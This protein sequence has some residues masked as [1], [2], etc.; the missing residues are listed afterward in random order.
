MEVEPKQDDIPEETKADSELTETDS[1]LGVAE[2]CM[3]QSQPYDR[4]EGNVNGIEETTV[5]HVKDEDS[6]ED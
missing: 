6:K 1:K 3:E 5:V 2:S 4:V